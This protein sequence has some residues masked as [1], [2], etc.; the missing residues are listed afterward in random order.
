MEPTNVQFILHLAF[1][2]VDA[3]SQ[4][5]SHKYPGISL[6][7][8]FP[9]YMHNDGSKTRETQAPMLPTTWHHP[10]F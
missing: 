5:D 10:G 6:R 1:V 4:S 9:K 7:T 3:K 2:A 8:M